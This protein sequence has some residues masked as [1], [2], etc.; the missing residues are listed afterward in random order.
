VCRLLQELKDGKRWT[1]WPFCP[2]TVTLRD[3]PIRGSA[4][5][6]NLVKIELPKERFKR[7]ESNGKIGSS[8]LPVVKAKNHTH[9]RLGLTILKPGVRVTHTRSLEK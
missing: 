1:M 9:P 7:K 4:G 5:I 2:I 6:L 8:K 3:F